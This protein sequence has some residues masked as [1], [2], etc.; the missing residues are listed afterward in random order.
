MPQQNPLNWR[1]GAG[2]LITSGGGDVLRDDLA[3][4]DT[5]LLGLINLDRPMVVLL[6]EGTHQ[7]A[8]DILDYYTALGGPIGEAYA[9]PEMTRQRF[10]TPNFLTLLEEAGTLY[11]H[12]DNPLPLLQSLHKT[13]AL[14]HIM[15]G[16]T[17]LQA[18]TIIATGGIAAALGKW[19]IGP[20]PDYLQAIGMDFLHNTV[21]EPHF[22][23]TEDAIILRN[24][25]QLGPGILGLGIPD[26][27]ALA[28]G[29]QGQVE[30]WG[31]NP[32]TVVISTRKAVRG[33][34]S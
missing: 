29:P 28:F 10:S 4:I 11:L 34:P 2:W 20:P 12:G 22:T 13:P 8:D 30:T 26:H 19:A 33:R 23:C 3:H 1:D 7:D 18:L 9:L 5:R 15:R 6:G 31:P 17:T 16:F 32:V 14:E 25:N 21:I 24:L 27:T